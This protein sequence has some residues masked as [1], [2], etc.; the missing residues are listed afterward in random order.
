MLFMDRTLG[1]DILSKHL[2]FGQCSAV[3]L[4]TCIG[5]GLLVNKFVNTSE[6]KTQ[7]CLILD[8]PEI[9]RSEYWVDKIKERI[10]QVIDDFEMPDYGEIFD[11][12]LTVVS[13]REKLLRSLN[14][15]KYYLM[16]PQPI[17]DF[18][19]EE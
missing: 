9:G 5:R 8:E 2:S 3:A 10:L 7:F 17:N 13:H 12:S 15:T 1:F 4:E 18:G 14:R 19:E 6:N 11:E 16:Q